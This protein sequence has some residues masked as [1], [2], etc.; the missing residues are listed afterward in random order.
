MFIGIMSGIYSSHF[1]SPG[2]AW[3]LG[4]LS[5]SAASGGASGGSGNKGVPTKPTGPTGKK[6]PV[7]A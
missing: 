3:W 2:L 7:A 4:R 1:I 5:E 6:T